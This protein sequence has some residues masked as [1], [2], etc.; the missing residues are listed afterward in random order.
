MGRTVSLHIATEIP[1]GEGRRVAVPGTDGPG[2]DIAVF[3]T[4]SG[5]V[6]ASQA[7]CPHRGGPLADGLLGAASVVCPLHEK[8]F[9][10]TNGTCSDGSCTI[11]VYPIHPSADGKLVVELPN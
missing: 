5:A 10:L 9:D 3:R 7:S 6:F 2:S 1:P 4:R 8:V 11:A